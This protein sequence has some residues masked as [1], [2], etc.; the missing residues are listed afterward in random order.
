MS[1]IV[2]I[3]TFNPMGTSF[4]TPSIVDT[5]ALANGFY[6]VFVI[7]NP[8]TA[9]VDVLMS[10]SATAPTM[11]AGY[12]LLR[13]VGA[14]WHNSG[15]L[16][17]Q[18]LQRGREFFWVGSSLDFT[19]NTLGTTLQTF[20]LGSIPTGVRVKAYINIIAWC[21]TINTVW[22]T[23]ETGLFDNAP[24]YSVGGNG[25]EVTSSTSGNANDL[26]IWTDTAAQICA[27]SAAANTSYRCFTRGWFDPLEN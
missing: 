20:A 12:T 19:T 4:T 21:P 9:A 25:I 15:R 2:D 6:H 8:T 16:F 18:I 5:G 7:K 3:P 11:P 23:H 10:R 27:R 24:G 26:Q 1:R 13:R 17:S 22:W 14:V